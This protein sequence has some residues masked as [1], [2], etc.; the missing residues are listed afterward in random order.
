MRTF[1]VIGVAE[2]ATYGRLGESGAGYYFIPVSQ[3]HNPQMILHVRSSPGISASIR[4]RVQG[5]IADVVPAL[6]VQQLQPLEDALAVAFLPQRLAAWISGIVGM[7]ALLIGTVGVYGVITVI[8]AQRRRELGIRVALGAKAVDVIALL[9]RQSLK[10]PVIGACIGAVLALV[11]SQGLGRFLGTVSPI[12]PVTWLA[13]GI[14][15]I[16][17][18]GTATLIPAVRA[19]KADP[20]ETL[21]ES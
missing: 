15:W 1:E 2:N 9:L 20:A 7:F 4:D 3:L 6:P 5:A 19:G 10:A 11:I 13:V 16:A 12:D 21:R 14:G 18:I 17:V 8:V